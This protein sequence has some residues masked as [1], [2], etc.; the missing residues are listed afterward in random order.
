M[1]SHY[2]AASSTT[3]ARRSLW[4][5]SYCLLLASLLLL[6]PTVWPQTEKK[7]KDVEPKILA[8]T[9]EDID[10]KLDDRWRDDQEALA[11]WAKEI[12]A[13]GESGAK[14]IPAA[15]QNLKALNEKIATLGLPTKGEPAEVVRQRQ[16]LDD[17]KTALENRITT[18]KVL[19]LRS[20]ELLPRIAD[21]Q[22]QLEAERLF[23]HGPSILALLRG[24][25]VQPGLWVSSSQAYFRERSAFAHL[26][27][28][29]WVLLSFAIAVAGTIGGLIRRRL[30]R[31]VGSHRWHRNLSS[32]MGRCLATS[33]AH[34]MPHLIASFAAA[35]FF[36][37][38]THDIRPIAV[39]N[40]FAY[41]LPVYF[42]LLMAIHTL[43]SPFRPAEPFLPIPAGAGRPLA[44]HLKV[45]A[46]LVFL[47][48]LLFA[49]FLAQGLSE[50][51]L[52][53]ARD[54]FVVAFFLNLTWALWWFSRIPAMSG[55]R[56]IQ[57]A[58]ALALATA[59]VA[60]FLGFRN[61]A[62]AA[63]EAVVG[64]LVALGIFGLVRQLLN[65]MFDGLN[66][67]R[68]RWHQRV[69]ELFA[70]STGDPVPG[71]VW[72]RIILSVF[73]WA[74]LL[75]VISRFWGVPDAYVLQA[76]A[77]IT[78]GFTVGSLPVNPAR[79]LLAIITL[80]ILLAISGWIRSRLRRGWMLSPR[81]DRGAREATVTMSG[82]VGVALSILVSLAVA[83]F[84][85]T[86][87]AII[88]GALSVGIGFGLQAIVNNFVSGLILLFERPIKTGDWIVVGNTEGYVKK[89]SIRS[90]MIQT[91]DRAH[92]IVPNSDLITNQV[93]NWMLYDPHGRIRVPV[94]VAYG[95]DTDKVREVM[96]QVAR[97]HPDVLSDGRVPEPRVLFVGFGDS[98][99]D[100]ELWCHIQQIDL[101]RPVISDLNFAIEKAFREHA[102]EIPY[103]QRD[104]NVRDWTK[105]TN[106]RKQTPA[107]ENE[108][109]PD[110]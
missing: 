28:M 36:L 46:A 69:R 97:D 5:G 89:I 51:V 20:D 22:K 52:L 93:T 10:H 40:V 101:R 25:E 72:V 83:G 43:L 54:A 57:I 65:E 41:G 71:L 88:A 73:F 18:C 24:E 14:C 7:D 77:W 96:L 70:L 23:A 16:E 33:V 90:T 104:V 103:P 86:N 29:Q 56:W 59:L 35:G 94:G 32:R 91:F 55:T 76:Y 62:L 12:R 26:S 64:T 21:L 78:K 95:S 39:V 79:I 38:A 44:V 110:P 1:Y 98:S 9:L 8:G 13:I 47:A 102:I 105:G 75:M 50:A 30:M 31:W 67:G 17:Q 106:R 92:V 37:L 45:F 15:E 11:A 19:I 49:T 68:H 74:V 85:F 108:N 87:L 100:F 84:E 27:V 34:Y 4:S 60:E 80:T 61:L 99:L 42:V 2:T 82:Y 66:S 3:R 6:S 58:L 107:A 48:Y 63:V 109:N 81:M 53:L